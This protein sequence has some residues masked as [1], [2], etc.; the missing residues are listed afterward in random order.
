MPPLAISEADVRRLVEIRAEAIE[1]ASASA[2]LA[3]AA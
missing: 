2:S 3:R 1:A